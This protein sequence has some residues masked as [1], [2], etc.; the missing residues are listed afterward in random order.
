MKRQLPPKSARR[1]RPLA[2]GALV[3]ELL[4]DVLADGCL[5]GETFDHLPVEIAELAALA[6][7]HVRDVAHAV[8]GSDVGDRSHPPASDSDDRQ[9]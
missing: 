4:F 7:Q 9:E 8:V 1:R 3:V 2:E 6:L 5:A